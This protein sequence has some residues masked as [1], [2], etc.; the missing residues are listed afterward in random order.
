MSQKA[1]KIDV[2]I[3]R[4]LPLILFLIL[5]D[6]LIDSWKG[7]SQYPFNLFHSNSVLYALALFFV[8]LADSKYHCVWNRAMYIE[9][10]V[11]PLVN[12]IDA[13]VGIF[14][15]VESLLITLSV[16]WVLTLVATV[17]LAVRHFLRPRFKRFRKRRDEDGR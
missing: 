16:T 15:S 2:F 14:P 7:I 6:I 10:M 11:V 4:F 5:G 8:S 9:L 3:V 13:K 17:F 12:Y 1:K